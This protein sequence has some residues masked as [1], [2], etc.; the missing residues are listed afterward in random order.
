VTWQHLQWTTQVVKPPSLFRPSGMLVGADDGAIDEMHLPIELTSGIGLLLEG[1]KQ[2]LEDPSLPP[3]VEAAR[4]R[5]L[6]EGI[7]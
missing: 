2:M 7:S 6:K 4:H 5:P 1:V 3:A